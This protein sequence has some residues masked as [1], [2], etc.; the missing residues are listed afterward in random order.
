[1]H[2][3]N[4]W[5]SLVWVLTTDKLLIFFCIHQILDRKWKYNE[6]VHQLFIDFKKSYDI[7]RKELLC[8][9]LIEF[10]VLMKLIRLIKMYLNQTYSKLNVD[11]QLCEMFPIQKRL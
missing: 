5:R 9:I 3:K 8:N 10:G 4:Y 6:T 7:V 2:R 1:M 11:E